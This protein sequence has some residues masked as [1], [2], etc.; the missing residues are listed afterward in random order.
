MQRPLYQAKCDRSRGLISVQLGE[1][2]KGMEPGSRSRDVPSI[3][4]PPSV[5]LAQYPPARP[6]V[7]PSHR[8]VGAPASSDGGSEKLEEHRQVQ[9]LS[10]I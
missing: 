6:C 4:R 2:C 1:R 8:E 7:F 5:P 10:R 9:L 3:P